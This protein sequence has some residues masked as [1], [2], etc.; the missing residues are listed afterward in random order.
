[1]CYLK[2]LVIIGYRD[3]FV[4]LFCSEIPLELRTSAKNGEISVDLED[5]RNEP[6]QK[7]K[8]KM[9]AFSGEGHRLGRYKRTVVRL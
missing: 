8:P 9:V 5:H 2:T 3:K 4:V 7:I 6:Y 1:M